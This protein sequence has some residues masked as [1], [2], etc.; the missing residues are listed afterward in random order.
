MAFAQKGLDY[1]ETILVVLS[2]SWLLVF[3][4]FRVIV[5]ARNRKPDDHIAKRGLRLFTNYV[6]KQLYQQMFFFL[7]PLYAAS[8]TW[9]LSSPNWWLPVL[10]LICAVLSTMDLVFDNFIM[11][12]RV[13]ASTMYGLCMFGVL[14]LILPLVFHTEHFIALLIAAAATAPTVALLSF[15]LRSLASVRGLALI[16][17][18]TIGLTSAAYFGR[19]AI[20]P[21]PM[22]LVAAGIGH[23]S[24]GSYECIPGPKRQMRPDQVDGLR[25]VSE[26]AEPGGLKSHIVHHWRYDGKEIAK[27]TELGTLATCQQEVFVSRLRSRALP[28]N[29]SGRL[30]CIV[31]TETGQLIGRR[32]VFIGFN[33]DATE[34]EGKVD[35]AGEG[36]AD[37]V[38]GEADA[39]L[40]QMDAPVQE[41]DAGLASG[42][43]GGI[44]SGDASPGGPAIDA[45]SEPSTDANAE[46]R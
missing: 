6:I 37:E 22:S 39:G 36:N 23:G 4:A 40:E 12:R 43:D 25:C 32:D 17:L 7:V 31:M 27:F 3:V 42:L 38:P 16:S 41:D 18:L 21:A 20:A 14:N 26:V 13:V 11:E 8:A 9:S 29:P 10:L 28:E 30:S 24:A 44:E 19:V 5:G 46:S 1:A 33:K 15:R 45:G 35:E 2:I 34:A